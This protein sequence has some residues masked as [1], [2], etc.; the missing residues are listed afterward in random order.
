[1]LI[2]D[3]LVNFFFWL[4]L[5]SCERQFAFFTLVAALWNDCRNGR[6]NCEWERV[7]Y[8]RN[9]G[10]I[11]EGA[12]GVGDDMMRT[13]RQVLLDITLRNAFGSV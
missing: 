5:W 4:S 1:M 10:T 8:I 12:E 11:Q 7:V 3:V 6:A 13:L 2:L 9:I